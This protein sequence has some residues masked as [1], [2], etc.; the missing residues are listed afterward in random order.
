MQE[1]DLISLLNLIQVGLQYSSV[2]TVRDQEEQN[3]SILGL[4][5]MK[6]RACSTNEETRNINELSMKDPNINIMLRKQL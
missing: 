3:A 6:Y 5:K 1:T 4:L 2:K